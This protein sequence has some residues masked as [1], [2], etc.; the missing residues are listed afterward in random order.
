MKSKKTKCRPG[1]DTGQNSFAEGIATIGAQFGIV[2]DLI[3]Q[4]A[5]AEAQGKD[6][7]EVLEIECEFLRKLYNAE[8]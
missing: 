6:R 5:V 4:K 1:L 3:V 8:S 7:K 2:I